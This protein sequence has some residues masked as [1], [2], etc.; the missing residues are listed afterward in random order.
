[1][2]EN[3]QPSRRFETFGRV[4]EKAVSEGDGFW[5]IRNGLG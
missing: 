2:G 3:A 5:F 4:N 1:M